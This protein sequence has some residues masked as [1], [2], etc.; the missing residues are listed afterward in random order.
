MVVFLHA[1]LQ[2]A[3]SGLLSAA[4]AVLR[5][6]KGNPEKVMPK[7]YHPS[8]IAHSYLNN[9]MAMAGVCPGSGKSFVARLLA[10]TLLFC[11][12]LISQQ[13]PAVILTNTA[14]VNHSFGN[15]SA[16]VDVDA[17]LR[18]S[19][20]IQLLQYAP[21]SPSA[22]S[23]FV[24]GTQ[25]STS[26]STSG[27]FT[28]STP[29][30][31]IAG[32]PLP[33]PGV[34]DLAPPTVISAGEP[35]FVRVDDYDQN[36]SPLVADTVVVQLGPTAAGDTVIIQLVET[37][38]NTGVF[39]GWV[40]TSSGPVIANDAFLSVAIED[41]LSVTYTDAADATD[42][43][44]S[45]V[46]VDPY[47]TLFSS[48]DGTPLDG[49]TLTLIDTVTGLQAT[50]F[51]SD[52]ISTFP[53]TITSG[54]SVT[55]SG[56]T[57]YNFPAGSYRYPFVPPGSYQIQVVPPGGFA[58]PS[59]APDAVIQSLPGA[60]YSIVVGSRGENFVVNP[61]PALHVDIP[62]DPASSGLYVSKRAN[63]NSVAI[64]EF[65]QYQVTVTNNSAG[66]Y[67]GVTLTDV[68]PAGFRIE[69][70]SVSVNDLSA[71]DPAISSDGRTMTFNLGAMVGAQSFNIQYVTGVSVGT[72][73]GNAINTAVANANGGIT[74]NIA[75]A[76]V[77]VENDLMNTRSHVVGRV[78]VDSCKA[79]P[80][81]E[82]F[83]AFRLQSAAVDNEV[84]F[85]ASIDVDTVPVQNLDVVIALP[86]VLQYVSGSSMLNGKRI[87]D[88]LIN[89][90]QLRFRLGDGKPGSNLAINFVT[91]PT[92]S[93]FGEF[94]TR[95][96]AEFI[97]SDGSIWVT[98]NDDALHTPMAY[99]TIKDFPRVV[100]TRFAT[101]SADLDEDN[102]HKLDQVTEILQT[103]TLRRVDIEGHADERQIRSAKRA[104]YFDNKQL[105]IARAEAVSEY[106]KETMDVND[107][108]IKIAGQ[109]SKHKIFYDALLR[110]GLLTKD[111]QLALNRRAEIIFELQDQTENTRF[112]LPVSDSGVQ[113]V[114]TVGK[115]ETISDPGLGTQSKGIAGIRLYLE[116]GRFVD[117]D[118]KGMFHFEGL[119]PGT[120]L[121]Q[122]DED[123]IPENL[124]I[125]SCE[126]NTRFAGSPYSRFVDTQGGSLWRA[127]FYV[128]EKPPEEIG[129]DVGIQ[130]SSHHMG[131]SIDY[132]VE[133]TGSKI[134]FIERDLV[135]ELPSILEYINGSAKLDGKSLEDPQQNG[136]SLIFRL[137]NVDSDMWRQKL[138]LR[139]RIKKLSVEGE[140]VAKAYLQFKS[141]DDAV[142]QSDLVENVMLK[143]TINQ[144][145]L[146][147]QANYN[148]GNLVL[149]GDDVRKLDSVVDFLRDKRIRNIIVTAH[150][151][152][153]PIPDHLKG[154]YADNY[155][156]STYRAQTVA[157][158]L[159][160]ELML[161]SK[162]IDAIGVGPDKPTTSN[163]TEKG[164]LENRRIQIH[165]TFADESTPQIIKISSDNSGMKI[166]D[167]YVKKPAGGSTPQK[168]AQEE[169][170]VDGFVNIKDGDR[171]ANPVMAISIRMDSRLLPVFKVDN[172][173]ISKDRIGSSTKEE[174]TGRTVHHFIGVNLG[175]KGPHML[176][177]K[178]MGPFGNARFTQEIVIQRTG[179][180]QKVVIQS[181]E[182]NVA[183]GKSPVRIKARLLDEKGELVNTQYELT[184]VD[185][186]L[187]PKR[188]EEEKLPNLRRPNVVI[189]DSNGIIEF[190]PVATS[191]SYYATLRFNDME[192]EVNTYVKPNYRE[193]IMVGLAEGTV[194]FNN[195]SGNMQNL[196][197]TDIEDEYYQ[198]GRLAFY[199]KGKVKGEYLL[200]MAYDNKREKLPDHHGL[201][202]SIDPD[203]F[204]T[205][206]G[207]NTQS[208]H[209][210]PSSEKLYLK[211]ESDQ[212]YTMFGDYQTGLTITELSR[213]NRSLTGLK[214]E[215][216]S[217]NVNFTLFAAETDHAFVKDELRG[218]GTSGLYY[219][220]RQNIVL[221]SE[222]IS[223]E[224]R[225][226]FK[227]EIVLKSR[228][229]SRYTDYTFDP[230]DGTVYFREPTYSM[231]ENFN[232]VY[233]V[234]DYEIKGNIDN[235]IT[236]GGRIAYKTSK[237]GP[238]IGA[239][240]IDE[241]TAGAEATLYGTDL[242]YKLNK[243]T[244][245]KLEYATSERSTG[246]NTL[247]GNAVLAEVQ[248]Q[249]ESIDSKIYFREQEADFGLG[250]QK[251]SESGTRKYG[252]DV[253][254]KLND[255]VAID[256]EVMRQQNLNTD[257]T[258]NVIKSKAEYRE[259]KYSLSG[260]ATL[261]RDEIANGETRESTL[262]TGSASRRF[263]ND[264]LNVYSGIELGL[265]NNENTDYPT[266]F[267]LGSEY[268]LTRD[269]D[270]FAHQEFTFGD[271]QDSQST[272]AG[273]R[274]KVWEGG[275]MRT[276]VENQSSEYG[277]RTF[278]NMGLTQGVAVNQFLKLDFGFERSHTIRDP[279]AAPF[280]VNVPPT[281]GTIDNDFTAVTLGATYTREFWSMTSRLETRRGDR[282]D[283][284]GML[285]G[286]YHEGRPGFGMSSSLQYF[287]TDRTN[288]TDNFRLELEFSIAYRPVESQWILL[289]KTKL[290]EEEESGSINSF[291]LRKWTNNISANY[292]YN[293][294]NQVSLTH[295]I[296][297][298]T[299][300][301]DGVSYSAITQMFGTEYRHDFNQHWD[302]GLQA[303]VMVSD[304]SDSHT[305]SYG[306]SIGHSFA[307]NVWLSLG[308]NLQGFTDGDFSG[309][310]Y[311]A[312]GVY[313]KFRFAFDH[314]TTR[315]AMAW[316]EK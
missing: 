47:G 116:D 22:T 150:T 249:S 153:Q 155:V 231:D 289:N 146:V 297:R 122:V 55:D 287:D 225:D 128:R 98:S 256:T 267:N 261:A 173:E 274:S 27:P 230:V 63:K 71:A 62:L 282:E 152:N 188:I 243:D 66:G 281:T 307:K 92:H 50:V 227:S 210:A 97:Q 224:T 7:D 265:G 125:Y 171:I 255:K 190:E 262:L 308:Y 23:T 12:L 137:N 31:D 143:Q 32:N 184:I 65:V 48:S 160:E 209:E 57:V 191:G 309:A 46:L 38:P 156:L 298:V 304:I 35:L 244:E 64:G 26:G 284:N 20:S 229:L 240:I 111:E 44:A 280:N 183:D 61:G 179:E 242:S 301:I 311:T 30:T 138:T 245:V 96:H 42:I 238:E 165:A 236:G 248:H 94:E 163:E 207:D 228:S 286:W 214:S 86:E 11:T 127:D 239:T 169:H 201:F 154:Q 202:G 15:A 134:N 208:S 300:D 14:T 81:D 241:G 34:L 80:A 6:F 164:R 3:R 291:T 82:G 166:K 75:K 51:G 17:T 54:G 174:G 213:Y 222:K 268:G 144:Q 112:I 223:I 100:R 203:K 105:S 29:V 53:A 313:L 186:T 198:D 296:K 132:I 68:L 178:G 258:R 264:R 117:T 157:A 84:K 288:G 269:T 21:G 305:Y 235:E 126:K 99:N 199:A 24:P 77:K 109:G 168:A 314:H 234:I 95:A 211:I 215:Y 194:G 76:E 254:S 114:R 172:K 175:E 110:E 119:K 60:P 120:H 131:N 276:S 176:T 195:I 312:N 292:L 148:S 8:A 293:R 167:V 149:T 135:L 88:P 200:T 9:E 226:R 187:K 90:Q 257:T 45:S 130:L 233:I 104:G 185:G 103:Q 271:Q 250:Q 273:I 162:Q 41:T 123:S 59:N 141:T 197:G 121:I 252:A 232:P 193:W 108:I 279:G 246:A 303:S 39:V 58:H 204:Y 180:P 151:D 136:N 2:H 170:P 85:V 25:Y 310:K 13:V 277:P 1:R 192:F 133:L 272:R 70:G 4:R 36:A 93:A 40:Q 216:H 177:V 253:R 18:T 315:K 28:P 79:V 16:S 87:S 247:E 161:Y 220:S 295:G 72:R 147:Y 37:G 266:R 113:K 118:E 270:L 196:D 83:V 285:L 33:V 237:S 221:N 205:L 67:T 294:Q 316:W 299:D 69:P 10:W 275:T 182:G 189:L 43:S 115:V 145:R 212:F 52:G 306:A 217:D 56:G 106:L 129:G 73:E 278:A 89:R 142:Q 139:T 74:S 259:N 19:S 251:G 91:R 159:K 107:N 140:Y 78:L 101:A 102:K 5:A 283:K 219:L 49:A 206:Y 124:E 290:F 302:A 263:F 158:Y 181:T 218:D 260:G